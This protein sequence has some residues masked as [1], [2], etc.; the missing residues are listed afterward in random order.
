M[1]GMKFLDQALAADPGI[2][3]LILSASYSPLVAMDALKRG[4]CDY[5]VKPLDFARLAKLLDEIV[6][7]YAIR[8][9]VRELEDRLLPHLVFHGMFGKSPAMLEVFDLARKAARLSTNIL[10]S[11]PPGSGKEL[12][13]RRFIR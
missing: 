10:I 1:D 5:L 13:A 8:T 11:G 7:L 4:A 9:H 12:L 2:H 6:E 3:V